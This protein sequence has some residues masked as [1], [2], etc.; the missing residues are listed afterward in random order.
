MATMTRIGS[1]RAVPAGSPPRALCA[2]RAVHA[3]SGASTV[4]APVASAPFAA[5]VVALALFA[6]FG[7]AAHAQAPAPARSFLTL[8]D[9]E[10]M[11][12][13]NNPTVAQATA[14]VVAADARAAQAGRWPNPTIGY[15]A[16]EVS[17]SPTIRWGE[18][19]IFL[20]Q[21]FPISGRLGADRT[22]RER[23][24]DE[25][26][27]V[28]EGQ[29][30][31]VLTTVRLL[32]R[33]ALIAARRVSVREELA[34]HGQDLVAATRQLANIGVADRIDV[35][36][37]EADAVQASVAV[38]DAR[39]AERQTWRQ[40][41][42]A[43]GDPALAP[44]SLAGDPDTVP[45][46][47][48]YD[49][50]LA[51]LL[52][53]SPELHAAGA[54]VARAAA[55]LVRARKETTPDLVVRAGPR[56]NREL[57][58][59]GPAPVG[60][61]GFADVGVTVP[62]W[63]RNRDGVAAAEA[64]LSHARAEV[65]RVELDLRRRFAEVFRYYAAA[66]EEVRAYRDEIAPRTEEAH[67]LLGDRYRELAAEYTDVLAAQRRMLDI[68]ERYLDAL[69]RSWRAALLIDGLLLDGGFDPPDRGAGLG[70][71]PSSQP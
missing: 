37:A 40:L 36:V 18:H 22:L 48:D 11:A 66:A 52:R 27:A 3:R 55:A 21:V 53:D 17:G 68:R 12:L 13:A 4:R 2:T 19:G 29:R 58:D 9:L 10:R 33:S 70:R 46:P 44:A 63:N 7:M 8:D 61:E 26:R 39:H 47:A 15:T 49:T 34:A 42:Q 14:R 20:E 43:V 38:D 1:R 51:R 71:W 67:R 64:D 65:A 23:E 69:G 35:L 57:F 60:W 30:L 54:G 16:E 41:A 62:L 50:A 6:A 56:Y 24:A 31:R 5:A 28:R 32:Y 59:P 25:A 45:P